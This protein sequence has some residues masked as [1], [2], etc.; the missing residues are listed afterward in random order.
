[1]VECPVTEKC[2]ERSK[3]LDHRCNGPLD[4][5]CNGPTALDIYSGPPEAFK[6]LLEQDKFVVSVGSSHWR[7]IMER[8]F[9]RFPPFGTELATIATTND[10]NFKKSLHLKDGFPDFSMPLHATLS[11][12][13]SAH[14]RCFNKSESEAAIS[15]ASLLLQGNIDVHRIDETRNT[16]FSQLF[17]GLDLCHWPSDAEN[18]AHI[19]MIWFRLLRKANYDLQDYLKRES[20]LHKPIQ[21]FKFPH[22]KFYAKYIRL[23]QMKDSRDMMFF[24]EM[25]DYRREFARIY[26][27]RVNPGGPEDISGAWKSEDEENFKN[28]LNICTRCIVRPTD[29]VPDFGM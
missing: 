3:A 7:N 5:C 10:E 24:F 14:L 26:K 23:D 8:N 13:S 12:I 4:H 28:G 16:P 17:G 29:R 15:M 1:M 9:G 19:V 20:C 11:K 2:E 27:E 18:L 6:Y 21:V 25:Y 22:R